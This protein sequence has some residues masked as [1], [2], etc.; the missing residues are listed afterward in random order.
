[1]NSRE[2]GPLMKQWIEHIIEAG[3]LIDVSA[4]TASIKLITGDANCNLNWEIEF[5]EEQQQVS[6]KTKYEKKCSKAYF[7]TAVRVLNLIN[8]K[9]A[10]GRFALDVDDAVISYTHSFDAKYVSVSTSNIDYIIRTATTIAHKYYDN[11][12]KLLDGYSLEAINIV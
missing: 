7:Q 3:W 4:T 2:Q 9:A 12:A 5:K 11:I 1:M 8:T 6:I 10:I